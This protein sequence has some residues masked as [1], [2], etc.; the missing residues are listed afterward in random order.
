MP[1]ARQYMPSIDQ[2][3]MVNTA[4][5]MVR[6]DEAN[7]RLVAEWLNLTIDWA[8]EICSA[9]V[10]DQAVLSF[11]VLKHGLKAPSFC[12]DQNACHGRIIY[13]DLHFYLR[14]LAEGRFEF[15]EP[16]KLPAG[17]PGWGYMR[18]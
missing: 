9:T 2:L 14:A 8:A 16:L 13:R 3:P 10:N 6:N 11:L 1:L 7:R 12:I 4:H 5:L 18:I 17:S 15:V